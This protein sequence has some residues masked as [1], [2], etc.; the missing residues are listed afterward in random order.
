V[1]GG[2]YIACWRG[3]RRALAR[4]GFTTRALGDASSASRRSALFSLWLTYLELFVIHAICQWCVVSAILATI[5]FVV[6]WLDLREAHA[7]LRRDGGETRR[8]ACAK[9]RSARGSG[10]ARWR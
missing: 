8:V 1:G 3:D 2:Y 6:S 7:L 10:R 4:R 9:A 5:L